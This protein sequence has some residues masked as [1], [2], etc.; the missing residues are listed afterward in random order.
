MAELNPVY[1]TKRSLE[2]KAFGISLF[3]WNHDKKLFLLHSRVNPPHPRRKGDLVLQ[4]MST[5]HADSDAIQGGESAEETRGLRL[6][7]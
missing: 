6:F 4:P 2:L 3:D 7:A 5:V 1:G